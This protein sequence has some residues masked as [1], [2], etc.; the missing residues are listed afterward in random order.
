[1]FCRIAIS[2]D[3]VPPILYFTHQV[4]AGVVLG[5]FVRALRWVQGSIFYLGGLVGFDED[6]LWVVSLL[7]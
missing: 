2:V 3:P 7:Y 1:M 5:H 6:G 4:W